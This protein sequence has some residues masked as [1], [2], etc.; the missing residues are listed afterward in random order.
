MRLSGSAMMRV[1]FPESVT[2]KFRWSITKVPSSSASNPHS[3]KLINFVKTNVQFEDCICRLRS[4]FFSEFK[5]SF[6]L[7]QF[8]CDLWLLLQCI[9]FSNYILQC[10]VSVAGPNT[11][12][13][14]WTRQLQK[15]W[16]CPFNCVSDKYSFELGYNLSIK[17]LAI[18]RS[19]SP[20]FELPAMRT[21]AAVLLMFG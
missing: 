1:C 20:V 15:N 9:N 21:N 8:C 16:Y 4:N 12:A 18:S 19:M 3:L 5:G 10:T 7:Q 11:F 17:Y 2:S 13:I 6:R 14:V